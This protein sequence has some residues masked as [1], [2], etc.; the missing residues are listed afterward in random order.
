ML[1]QSYKDAYAYISTL[2]EK[3]N[4]IVFTNGC[5]DLVHAGHV[6]YL[7]EARALGDCLIVGIN[8]DASVQRL[9]GPKRPIQSQDDRMR[10]IASLKSVDAVILFEEDTPVSL[11][12]AL[13]PDVHVK[14]GDYE[15]A[16]L[17]EYPVVKAYGGEVRI[18]PFVAGKSSSQI[19][20]RILD[21]YA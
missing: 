19:I 5:F 15:V 8:S 18:L 1:F 20:E 3:N 21:A 12:S 16:S 9:K 10:V 17:P 6:A 7:S 11:I 14:G 13:Q 2:R 4:R